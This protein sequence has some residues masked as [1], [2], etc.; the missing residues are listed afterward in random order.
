MKEDEFNFK[1]LL[2]THFSK[3]EIK[4]EI[5]SGKYVCESVQLR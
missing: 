1:E 5:L 2:L 4:L 3:S